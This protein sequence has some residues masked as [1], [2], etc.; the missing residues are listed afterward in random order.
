MKLEFDPSSLLQFAVFKE[1]MVLHFE[2]CTERLVTG[3]SNDNRL[4]ILV[5]LGLSRPLSLHGPRVDLLPHS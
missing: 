2:K 3:S 5:D 4:P 1:F